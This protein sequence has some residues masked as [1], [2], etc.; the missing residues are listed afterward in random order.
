MSLLECL[1]PLYHSKHIAKAKIAKIKVNVTKALPESI[2][3]FIN[4]PDSFALVSAI[5]TNTVGEIY[6][7]ST[8]FKNME[9][10]PKTKTK[11]YVADFNHFFRIH[12]QSAA[13]K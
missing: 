5:N 2:Y 3:A 6:I 11:A 8:L 7:S 1:L 10:A 9:T 4:S 13:N 12:V